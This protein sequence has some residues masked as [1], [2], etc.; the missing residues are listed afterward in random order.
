M[1]GC[2]KA[3]VSKGPATQGPATVSFSGTVKTDPVPVPGAL[4]ATA[5]I[6]KSVPSPDDLIIVNHPQVR[7]LQSDPASTIFDFC[8]HNMIV[9]SW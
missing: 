3:R 6:D 4:D 8:L 7:Q 9:G 1:V 2:Q 5:V